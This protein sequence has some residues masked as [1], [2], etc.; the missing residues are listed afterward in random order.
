MTEWKIEN[1]PQKPSELQVI[2]K[3]L[4]M[5][6]RNIHEQYHEAYADMDAYTDWECECRKI[7]FAEY[8]ALMMS[9]KIEKNE[10]DIFYIAMMSDIDLEE[11]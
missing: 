1:C 3:D 7:T 4:Y 2:G 11:A 10:S 6:R 9:A 5:Q 8:D